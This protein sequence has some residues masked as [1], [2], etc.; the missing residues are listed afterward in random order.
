MAKARVAASLKNSGQPRGTGSVR[1]GRSQ[2][3]PRSSTTGALRAVRPAGKTPT[4][5]KKNAPFMY[6][7]ED[8]KG[9][10]NTHDIMHSPVE[11][12]LRILEKIINGDRLFTM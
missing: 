8:V 10:F 11:K 1:I 12:T 3:A 5:A 2:I 4:R 7:R 9:T 6:S